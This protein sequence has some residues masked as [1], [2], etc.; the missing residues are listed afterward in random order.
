MRVDRVHLRLLTIRR[1]SPDTPSSRVQVEV[2][3]LFAGKTTVSTS[4]NLL[5]NR[6]QNKLISQNFSRAQFKHQTPQVARESTQF[7]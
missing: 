6:K 4:L 3:L 1:L 7:K 5:L 2:L